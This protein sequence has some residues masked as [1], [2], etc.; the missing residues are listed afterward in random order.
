MCRNEATCGLWGSLFGLPS[1]NLPEGYS[2]QADALMLPLLLPCNTTT[3]I[4]TSI[5]V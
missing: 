2:S 4:S 1:I 5:L 3:S